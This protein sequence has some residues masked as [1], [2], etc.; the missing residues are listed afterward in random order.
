MTLLVDSGVLL[1]LPQRTDPNHAV[2]RQAVRGLRA[3]GKAIVTAPQNIAEFWNVCTRPASARGGFRLSVD[4]TDRRLRL[5]ERI[6]RVLPDSAES[7]QHWRR[8]IIV[9]SVRGVQVHDARLVGFMLAHG[10]RRILTLNG[11]DFAR[12]P[13]VTALTPANVI[14]TP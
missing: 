10:I 6:V 14:A 4:E 12:Y 13:E 9:R 1:R 2:V 11:G 3:Q 5:I 8:L 7:Y